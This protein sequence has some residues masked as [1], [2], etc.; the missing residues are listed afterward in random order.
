MRLLVNA[1]IRSKSLIVT[2]V[3]ALVL[4]AV[5]GL[6]VFSL[7]EIRTASRLAGA[8]AELRSQA[9]AATND[10]SQ[11]Q[12]DLYRAINLQLQSAESATVSATGRESAQ[13]VDH[14]K[15]TLADLKTDGLGIDQGLVSG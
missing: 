11:A 4:I 13:A 8:A 2:L 10:L 12:A 7:I 15:R 14:A 9:L 6:A 3:S 1:S 5:S